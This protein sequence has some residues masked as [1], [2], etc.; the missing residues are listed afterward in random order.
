MNPKFQIAHYL[1][2]ALVCL[3]TVFIVRQIAPLRK[4]ILGS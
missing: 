1:T 2:I 3:V 4:L